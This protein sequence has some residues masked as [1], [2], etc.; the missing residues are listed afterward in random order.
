MKPQAGPVHAFLTYL[1][2]A[3]RADRALIQ[4]A[5]ADEICRGTYS[6][7]PIRESDKGALEVYATE[8]P[9]VCFS[10]STAGEQPYGG[11][12]GLK[13]TGN[14][15]YI[16]KPP[17][18]HVEPDGRPADGASLA[19]N[20]TLAALNRVHAHVR[21]GTLKSESTGEP[22]W[23]YADGRID[24]AES[25]GDASLMVEGSELCGFKLPLT[26]SLAERP[27][28]AQDPPA[29]AAQTLTLT[30]YD[31]GTL[32]TGGT[33]VVKGPDVVVTETT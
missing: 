23:T 3:L 8:I 21:A 24:K 9:C 2:R 26:L 18:G 32:G 30:P 4:F 12:N 13:L 10:A 7:A 17:R 16:H 29:V 6:A 5:T 22:I 27:F 1:Y 28:L 14:L 15:W 31:D 19:L 25:T 20:W 11:F 33:A